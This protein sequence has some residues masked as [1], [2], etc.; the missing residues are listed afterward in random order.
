MLLWEG[1]KGEARV[2]LWHQPVWGIFHTRRG[3]GT[4]AVFVCVQISFRKVLGCLEPSVAEGP[5]QRLVIC[6]I[7]PVQKGMPRP[8]RDG[9][10]PHHLCVH[11]GFLLPLLFLLGPQPMTQ[12]RFLLLV[13][14]HALTD[15]PNP[16]NDPPNSPPRSNPVCTEQVKSHPTSPAQA[17]VPCVTRSDGVP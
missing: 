9:S 2:D 4:I 10:S 8:G 11:S 13:S 3:L 6:E 14:G 16:I 12:G 5:C 7:V 17:P 1:E 15:P